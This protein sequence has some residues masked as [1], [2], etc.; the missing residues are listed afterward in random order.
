MIYATICIGEDWCKRYSDD[1]NKFGNENSI[2][3]LTDFTE[4]FGNCK[5]IKY[6]RDI[7]SYYEKL[8]F[9]LK[10]IIEHK[11]R[12]VFV[13]ADFLE[14]NEIRNIVDNTYKLDTDSIYALNVYDT[15]EFP[16][17]E[18]LNN[19]SYIELIDIYRSYNY[20]P[21]PKYLHERLFSLP[22]KEYQTEEI[23]KQI[24]EMQPIFEER[25]YKGKIWP[26]GHENQRWSDAGCGY[27]EGGAL[28]IIVH[29]M[30]IP[31]KSIKYLKKPL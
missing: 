18:V 25:Y 29:N 5:T 15:K 2:Y 24:V 27:A 10:L 1:I 12:V 21:F 4:Y 31:V 11:E 23:L 8:P 13:D 14:S 9:T 19:P 6:S 3:V 28:S 26:E 17:D 30:N 7:F 16:R 20:E 22:Y